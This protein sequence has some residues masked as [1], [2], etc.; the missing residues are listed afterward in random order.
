ML[1]FIAETKG[2]MSTLQLR[3][4]EDVMINCAR[5]LFERLR[6]QSGDDTRVRYDVVSSYGGMM[7]MV[8]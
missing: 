3:G 7:E 5:K 4:I 8:R 2:S 6:E 1:L